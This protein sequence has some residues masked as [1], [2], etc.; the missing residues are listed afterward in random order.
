VVLYS[1]NVF[2]TFSLSL[3]GLC[4]FWWQRRAKGT[5]WRGRLVLSGLGFVVTASILAV[6]L[7][8]KFVEGG[9]VTVMITGLVISIG[10]VVRHHYDGA[11]LEI[12]KI[13]EVFAQVPFGSVTAPPKPD[14]DAPTAAFL[15]SSSRGGGLHALMW[16]QRMFPHHFRNFV[17]LNARTVDS[18]S[19]GGREQLEAMKTEANAAL[20]YFVNYCNSRGWA[21]K[22]YLSFGTDPIDEVARLAERVQAEFPNTIFF[23]SKLIFE[24]ENWFVR[25]LHN[26]APLVLQRRFHLRN[27]QMVILP[28]KLST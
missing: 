6:T 1:I 19:Y 22:S 11:K 15:V 28:M 26:Q 17:F 4:K 2:L 3:A 7:V 8:E 14:P 16:V 12:R 18:Q 24:H 21:A 23:T 5:Q 10:L 27:M 13:D 20:S 9:W 25:L